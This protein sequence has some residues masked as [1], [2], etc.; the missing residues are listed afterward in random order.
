MVLESASEF[1]KSE[2]LS[3]YAALGDCAI[4]N[5]QITLLLVDPVC[6]IS[7]GLHP[8]PWTYFALMFSNYAAQFFR[9]YTLFHRLGMHSIF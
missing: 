4:P 6:P 1:P 3:D 9:G 5:F 2:H 8:L 7:T